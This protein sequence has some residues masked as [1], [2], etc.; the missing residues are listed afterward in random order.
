[1]AGTG[2]PNHNDDVDADGLREAQRT[3]GIRNL[4]MHSLGVALL[5]IGQWDDGTSPSSSSSSSPPPPRLA[6]DEI[7]QVR[8]A[9]DVAER[10]SRLGPRY[11]KIT[12]QCLDCDFGFGKDLAAPELQSAIYRDVVC[13][14]RN[15]IDT[16]EGRRQPLAL[17]AA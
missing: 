3:Y 11:H 8:R 15:L 14:L 9:A 1:M 7:A 4:T 10:G 2:G 6:V 16:L 5:Q 17:G 12:Q 13:E